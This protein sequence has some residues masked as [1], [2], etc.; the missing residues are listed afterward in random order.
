MKRNISRQV[1]GWHKQKCYATTKQRDLIMLSY[2]AY[3]WLNWR[4]WVWYWKLSQ[5][6][7]KRD[8]VLTIQKA[9]CVNTSSSCMTQMHS[10]DSVFIC[11]FWLNC[12][13][14][15]CT[16]VAIPDAHIT[17][18]AALWE[19]A[20]TVSSS[21]SPQQTRSHQC[22]TQPNPACLDQP[23]TGCNVLLVVTFKKKAAPVESSPL[24]THNK[25]R[26]LKR[27]P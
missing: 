24:W 23:S 22:G 10:R 14:L 21:K 17:V 9:D 16:F 18:M 6:R 13:F 19:M 3:Q 26:Q 12:L 25:D 8:D 15:E 20:V 5:S 27:S 2:V 11:N 1:M 4:C 7:T